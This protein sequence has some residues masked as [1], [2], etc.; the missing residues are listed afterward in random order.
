MP[1][2]TYR[3][4]QIEREMGKPIEGIL[5]E[6]CKKHARLEHVAAKL[7]VDQ[8]TLY[9]WLMRFGFEKRWVKPNRGPEQEEPTS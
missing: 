3:M 6:L 4:R 2:K 9:T 1:Q 7:G 8:S 5:E